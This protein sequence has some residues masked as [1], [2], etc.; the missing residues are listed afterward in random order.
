[1]AAVDIEYRWKQADVLESVASSLDD[2]GSPSAAGLGPRPRVEDYQRAF[3]ELREGQEELLDLL[4]CEYRARH[5]WGDRPAHAE[6]AVRFS[7]KLAGLGEAII[8]AL[9]AIDA[10][11]AADPPANIHAEATLLPTT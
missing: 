4:G 1:L 7:T 6:Y 3:P 2:T 5:R 8:A 10:E 9:A 11:L